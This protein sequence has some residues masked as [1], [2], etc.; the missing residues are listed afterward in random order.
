MKKHVLLPCSQNRLRSPT[1][2]AVIA[3][4]PAV[5]NDSAG[6]DHDAEVP[7]SEEQVE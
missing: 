5:E 1:A 4:H 6:L 2:E 7:L 3:E